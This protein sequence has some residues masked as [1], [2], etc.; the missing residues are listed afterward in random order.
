[1]SQP[2]QLPPLPERTLFHGAP[3][4]AFTSD[5]MHAYATS[6]VQA[7]LSS[8]AP[9]DVLTLCEWLADTPHQ[10]NAVNELARKIAVQS[11]QPAAPA[12]HFP[13]AGKM[14]EVHAV[15]A[16]HDMVKGAPVDP[17]IR[18]AY[19]SISDDELFGKPVAPVAAVPDDAIELR[20]MLCTAYAGHLAY[21]DDGE[22]QD[23]RMVPFIDFLRDSVSDIKAKML[24]RA[25]TLAIQRARDT[26]LC[27]V[28]DAVETLDATILV[29]EED[30]KL[31]KAAALL[32]LGN[33][34]KP[35][36]LP[37]LAASP[38][39]PV[40]PDLT[41]AARDVLAERQRQISTK[42]WTPEHDD[43][44]ND[45]SL[46]VAA[47]CY[48]LTNVACARPSALS[49]RYLATWVGWG[50]GW[51]KPFNRRRDLIKA[52]ALILAE[53]ERLDRLTAAQAEGAQR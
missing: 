24:R 43:K 34:L 52:G 33:M 20:R 3:A 36:Y 32:R 21:T 51:F 47:A 41:A 40:Q 4:A 50:A 38:T 42:G 12:D 29:D 6:A 18:A 14:I 5:Q 45:G 35:T 7:A 27:G 11:R 39:P 53:I 26:W 16:L 46:S 8:Q 23:A 25:P 19:A 30:A 13:D 10:S 49:T 15:Q 37:N 28:A 2:P 44:H 22:A 9:A 48:A 1:M 17:E 31:F